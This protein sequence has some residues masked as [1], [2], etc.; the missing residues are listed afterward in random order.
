MN[1][2]ILT[3]FVNY[4]YF[5]F[6]KFTEHSYFPQENEKEKHRPYYLQGLEHLYRFVVGGIGGGK[7]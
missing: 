7:P 3:Y 6:N 5:P 1:L 2:F 4:F